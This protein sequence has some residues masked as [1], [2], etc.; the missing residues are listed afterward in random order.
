M[1]VFASLL[2]EAVQSGALDVEV[3]N[4]IVD[5]ICDMRT[6]LQTV[7]EPPIY[8][9]VSWEERVQRVERMSRIQRSTLPCPALPCLVFSFPGP[10]HRQGRQLDEGQRLHQRAPQRNY[11]RHAPPPARRVESKPVH[12]PL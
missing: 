8:L 1:P 11:V 5:C 2:Q 4:A 7:C 9:S 12:C 10:P 6:Y 3:P